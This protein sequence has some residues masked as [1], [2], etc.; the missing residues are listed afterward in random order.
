MQDGR[1]TIN[2]IMAKVYR[3]VDKISSSNG[4]FR[5]RQSGNFEIRAGNFE[6]E[7]EISTSSNWKFRH[8]NWKFRVRTGN[9]HFVQLEISSLNW[10]FRHPNWK[11]RVAFQARM[12]HQY[13]FVRYWYVCKRHRVTLYKFQCNNHKLTSNRKV[14]GNY[15][16]IRLGVI[17]NT[18]QI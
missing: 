5:L 12:W 7:L 8:S 14:M 1:Q 16:Y 6:L 11:F 17:V 4:K 2:A 15:L 13:A 18:V 3:V 10:K 9:F